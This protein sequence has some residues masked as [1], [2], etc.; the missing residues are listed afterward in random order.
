[1]T[2]MAPTQSKQWYREPWPWILM[3]GPAVV[4]VAALT[5]AWIAVSHRDALVEDDYYKR[6]LAINQ[7]L[8]R[9]QAAAALHLQAQLMVGDN[10][11][12]VR[13]MVQSADP[14]GLPDKLRLRVLHPT[15]GGMDQVVNLVQSGG[16]LYEGQLGKLG[17]ATKWRLILEDG[18]KH[19]RLTGTWHIAKDHVVD[20]R[21]EG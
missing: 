12:R 6:G 20:L 15:L 10:P 21:S 4:V 9:D 7:T 3:A 1:M 14:A 17:A 16:G 13:L 8:E 19:W 2:G 11:S 18:E 5:T